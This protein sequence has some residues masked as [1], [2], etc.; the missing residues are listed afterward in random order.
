MVLQRLSLKKVWKHSCRTL[1]KLP[2]SVSQQSCY[3]NFCCPQKRVASWRPT[4][5][6]AAKKLNRHCY[7]GLAWRLDDCDLESIAGTAGGHWTANLGRQDA[8]WSSTCSLVFGSWMRRGTGSWESIFFQGLNWIVA[9]IAFPTSRR[10]YTG[11]I[12][13]ETCSSAPSNL[14]SFKMLVCPSCIVYVE[15]QNSPGRLVGR[16]G[17]WGVLRLFTTVPEMFRGLG[18]AF[19][20]QSNYCWV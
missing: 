5:D 16:F 7:R 6:L 11:W 19:M 20:L 8:R 13:L 9:P 12:G 2:A 10:T 18:L 3:S 15:V 1:W 14:A 17:C 4:A